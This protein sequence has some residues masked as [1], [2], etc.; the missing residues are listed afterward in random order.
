M[1]GP[2]FGNAVKS[3]SKQEKILQI[4]QTFFWNEKKY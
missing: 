2:L 3:S 4:F 1:N